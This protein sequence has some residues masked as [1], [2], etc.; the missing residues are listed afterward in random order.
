M[1][2]DLRLS[3]FLIQRFQK[4]D[5]NVRVNP[6]V[7]STSL[8]K[9]A[10]RWSSEL[11]FLRHLLRCNLVSQTSLPR[12]THRLLTDISN[13]NGVTP[14]TLTPSSHQWEESKLLIGRFFP[15]EKLI[16]KRGYSVGS[17]TS[18]EVN[19]FES[20]HQFTGGSPREPFLPRFTHSGHEQV[21]QEEPQSTSVVFSFA[22]VPTHIKTRVGLEI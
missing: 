9:T 3:F 16:F 8:S 6:E 4:Q 18:W 17:D 12:L 10:A 1:S 22:S 15:E 11:S 19:G 7:L 21:L 2:V 13:L 14:P 5:R 20:R